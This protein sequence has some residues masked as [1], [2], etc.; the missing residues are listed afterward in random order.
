M[1]LDEL[2]KAVG[3]PINEAYSDYKIVNVAGKAIYVQNYLK[4]LSYSTEQITLKLK[5]NNL[6]IEGTDLKIVELSNKNI[7]I[8]GLINKNYLL[9]EVKPDENNK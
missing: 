9:K 3:L 2:S 8:K 7:L 1:F 5:T 6:V 4:L